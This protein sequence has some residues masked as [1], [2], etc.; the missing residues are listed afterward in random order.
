[1]AKIKVLDLAREVGIEDDKLLQKLKRMG[2]K[3]KDKKPAEA[4]KIAS[5]TDEKVIERDADK[6]VVEKRVKPTIIRRRTRSLEA[7]S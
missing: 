2:V 7:H 3:V 6:E 4:E 1:M 5:T